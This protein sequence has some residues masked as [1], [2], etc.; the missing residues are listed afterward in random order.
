MF[1]RIVRIGVAQ[2]GPDKNEK[3]NYTH[4]GYE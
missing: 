2:T 4:Y 3:S 1:L